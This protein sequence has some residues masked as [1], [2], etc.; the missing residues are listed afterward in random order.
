MK[1]HLSLN[2]N[3]CLHSKAFFEDHDLHN[4]TMT[5]TISSSLLRQSLNKSFPNTSFNVFTHFY[6]MGLNFFAGLVA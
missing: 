2:E 4:L 1:T 3:K 5:Y 6:V